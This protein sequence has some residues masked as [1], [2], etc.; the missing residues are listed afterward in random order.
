MKFPFLFHVHYSANG[1]LYIGSATERYNKMQSKYLDIRCDV[2]IEKDF[3]VIILENYLQKL[4][5]IGKRVGKLQIFAIGLNVE[6]GK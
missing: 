1:V 3:R 2:C 5:R 4:K 6:S